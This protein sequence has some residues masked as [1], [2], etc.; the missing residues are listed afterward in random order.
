[1]AGGLIAADGLDNFA[2]GISKMEGVPN[3]GLGGVPKAK[4]PKQN[5]PAESSKTTNSGNSLEGSGSSAS[6]PGGPKATIAGTTALRRVDDVLSG[7]PKGNQSL[8]RTV[9]DEASLT[10]TFSEL[11]EGGTPTTWKKFTGTV[12]E[13]GDGVQ[14][15]LR[16][17]S[18]S[19]GSTIDIRMP[20]GKLDRIHV[21]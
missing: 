13:R 15:G 11:T 4:A 14:I 20:D 3:P 9:P 18:K 21:D 6:E 10:R 12:I 16:S 1:M 19:G 5:K 8:L 7:L 17:Y 2:D